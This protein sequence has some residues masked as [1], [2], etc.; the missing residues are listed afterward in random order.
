MKRFWKNAVIVP[1]GDGHSVELDGRPVKLPSGKL[2]IV[3]FLPLA[4]AI[5]GE[6]ATAPQNFSP[7]NLPF[8][9]LASTA[10]ERIAPNRT[11][12]IN[13]LTAYGMNDLLCY[14]A[15]TPEDL[16]TRQSNIWNPWLQWAETTHGL[17]LLSTAG[18]VPINQPPST[19][20]ALRNI[21]STHSDQT[22][23]ALGVIVPALGSLILG[24]ALT[25][26]TLTPQTA[27][28]AAFLDELWQEEQWGTDKEAIARRA[29]VIADVDISTQ[30]MYLCAPP[31]K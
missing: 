20:E 17:R 25:A 10:Q 27:C 7:D 14:R 8:T 29:K 18:L 19:G 26:K 24:L 4:E 12:I 23:A 5:A 28:D 9:R 31:P 11:D 2:L 21:L 15:E 1:Q 16:T 6:W 22:I 3:S 30:F 13:Q